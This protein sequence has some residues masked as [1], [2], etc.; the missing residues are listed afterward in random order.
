MSAV[1]ALQGVVG[2]SP[3]FKPGPNGFGE[4]SFSV[5]VEYFIQKE[6]SQTYMEWLPLI[7]VGT[8]PVMK[9][10]KKGDHVRARAKPLVSR[11]KIYLHVTWLKIYRQSKTKEEEYQEKAY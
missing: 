9:S 11:G 8:N 1:L 2:Q 7:V 5:G 6:G 10:L 4:W 3:S